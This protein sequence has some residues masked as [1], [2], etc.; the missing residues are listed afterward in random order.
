[1]TCAH[2]RHITTERGA[3]TVGSP[4]RRYETVCKDCGELLVEHRVT[5]Y[6]FGRR[7]P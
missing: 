2:R 6:G 5:P 4:Y 1:M 7:T 3:P